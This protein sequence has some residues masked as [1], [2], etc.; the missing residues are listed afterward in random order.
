MLPKADFEV[1]LEVGLNQGEEAGEIVLRGARMYWV[2]GVPGS[3][4]SG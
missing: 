3:G 2:I 1:S 4:R